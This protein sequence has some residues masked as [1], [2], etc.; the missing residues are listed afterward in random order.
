MLLM[1]QYCIWS[2]VKRACYHLV[3]IIN[4][5]VDDPVSFRHHD[6]AQYS[7]RVCFLM[8][9]RSISRETQ[10]SKRYFVTTISRKYF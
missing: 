1:L 8:F 2:S 9:S 3:A 4:V 7:C 5:F 6:C 10:D